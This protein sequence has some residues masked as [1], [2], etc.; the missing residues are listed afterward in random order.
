[1]IKIFNAET[2]RKE[3]VGRTRRVRVFRQNQAAPVTDE[4]I[5]IKTERWE[6]SAARE[7]LLNERRALTEKI[8]NAATG[9]DPATIAALAQN[10][11]ID[12]QRLTDDMTV[13]TGTLLTEKND[14]DAIDPVRLRRY[15]PYVGK[16]E[17][18]MGS[19]DTVPLIDHNLLVDVVISL[20]LMG[21]GDKTMFRELVLNPFFKTDNVIQS[22]ARILVD[23]QNKEAI[24]PI[25]TFNFAGAN[26]GFTQAADT[27]GATLDLKIYNTVK[28]AIKKAVRLWNTPTGKQ[29]GLMAH[30]IYLLL[31]PIDAPDIMPVLN[32]ALRGLAGINQIVDPLGIDG[33]IPYGGGLNDGMK[34]GN[35]TLE[36]P[37]AGAGTFYIF[38]KNDVYGGYRIIKR[39]PTMEMGAGDPLELTTEKRAWHWIDGTFLDWILPVTAGGKNYGAV[40]KGSFPS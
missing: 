5:V 3:L 12:L 9:Y 2:M 33:V 27:A 21:F 10:Y 1:M 8:K 38:V 15:M 40:I 34:W 31:N 16:A 7:T 28:A 14:A 17:P 20:I 19:G 35:E 32:G 39:S 26:A 22:A 29:N 13:H 36:Y 23:E 30:K 6:N 18:V 24:G 37:G 25:V 11:V 4:T